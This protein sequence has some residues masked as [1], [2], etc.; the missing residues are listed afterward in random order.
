MDLIFGSAQGLSCLTPFEK[1][2]TDRF[3]AFFMSSSYWD[4]RYLGSV[5]VPSNRSTT[6]RLFGF[7]PVSSKTSIIVSSYFEAFCELG[8]FTLFQFMFTCVFVNLCECIYIYT[9]AYMYKAVQC[10]A[11]QCNA[12][13]CNAMQCNAMQCNAMQCNAMQCCIALHCKELSVM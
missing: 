6:T 4:P 10:N 8:I 3:S 12:M 5:Y 7:V 1:E 11:M 9:Y 2:Q 13:Q